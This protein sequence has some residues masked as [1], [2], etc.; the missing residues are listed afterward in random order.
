ME[1][2]ASNP[3]IYGRSMASRR[4]DVKKLGLVAAF[5]LTS[6]VLVWFVRR[7]WADHDVSDPGITL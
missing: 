5:V 3:A 7:S 2:D 1:V 4:F 6:A